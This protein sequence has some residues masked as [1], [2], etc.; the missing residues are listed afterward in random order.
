MNVG[1][2]SGLRQP[3]ASPPDRRQHPADPDAAASPP[4]LTSI[5]SAR[6]LV[7]S[8]DL[9]GDRLHRAPLSRYHDI[10]GDEGRTLLTGHR[11]ADQREGALVRSRTGAGPSS[12]R[13]GERGARRHT[14][15]CTPARGLSAEAQMGRSAAMIPLGLEFG[16]S[17]SRCGHARARRLMTP[18]PSHRT[19]RQPRSPAPFAVSPHFPSRRPG[20][21]HTP[22]Q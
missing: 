17:R 14:T 4:G 19:G 2:V 12:G 3:D 15:D 9:F 11:W 10:R 22:S 13:S 18:V 6:R 1:E 5:G 7:G 8:R 21:P 16:A 20:H